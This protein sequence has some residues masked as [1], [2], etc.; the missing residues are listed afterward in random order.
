MDL[1][2]HPTHPDRR[3]QLGRLQRS[4]HGQRRHCF[5]ISLLLILGPG[6]SCAAEL[7]PETLAAW[8]HYIEQAKMRMNLRLDAGSHFLW[9]DEESDRARRVRRGEI[10][11]APVNGSGRTEVPN[12]LIHD[13]I[14]AAFFPDTTIEKVFV[15]TGEYACY[16][17]FYKPTVVESKLLST[18]GSES[19]FSLRWLKKALF[20]TTVMDGDYKAYY[21]RRSE[22]SRYGFVWSTRIQDVVN[23]GQSSELKL[24]PGTGSGFIWRLFSISRFEERDGGVYVELEAI[25]LSRGVPPGLGWLVNPVVSRLSQSSL[26]TFFSQTREAVR[27]L[28]QRAGLDSCGSRSSVLRARSSK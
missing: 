10:L 23:D 24:P 19:S 7:Q 21:L 6:L 5:A 13:W 14:V 4:E 8:N 9:L 26:V 18:D 27:S 15:T 17:D 28:P 2:A 11:V 22:K 1:R 12:G 3:I 25:A 20:V 16:K